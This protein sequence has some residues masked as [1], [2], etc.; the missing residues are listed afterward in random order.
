MQLNKRSNLCANYESGVNNGTV[1]FSRISQ[2][3][4]VSLCTT[5]D[6]ELG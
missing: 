6:N 3:C 1:F 5:K 4:D 2:K